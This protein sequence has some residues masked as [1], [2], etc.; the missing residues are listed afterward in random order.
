VYNQ[1]HTDP[2][3]YHVYQY[4]KNWNT[5]ATPWTKMSTWYIT[6]STDWMWLW[7][8]GK[9]ALTQPSPDAQILEHPGDVASHLNLLIRQHQ[10]FTD[11]MLPTARRR[12]I[13]LSFSS[14]CLCNSPDET[15][16]PIHN[17]ISSSY[18]HNSAL[19]RLLFSCSMNHNRRRRRSGVGVSTQVNDETMRESLEGTTASEVT[20]PHR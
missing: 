7:R 9:P 16:R 2:T 18:C 13:C 17:R 11:H 8:E 5:P 1:I 20:T 6:P 4:S 3:L 10:C 19:S 12:R 14:I 15:T